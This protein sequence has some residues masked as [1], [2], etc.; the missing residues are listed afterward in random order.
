MMTMELLS[1]G[2][3]VL[4]FAGFAAAFDGHA[5]RLDRT[6]WSCLVLTGSV[7]FI[8]LV[9]DVAPW[10]TAMSLIGFLLSLVGVALAAY[11]EPEPESAEREP[12]WWPQFEREF[13]DY[14]R[15]ARP[16]EPRT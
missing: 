13:R 6:R 8:G 4:S 5:P 15:Q 14:V 10:A 7:L 3:F 9:V 2:G 11:A 1:L 16:H 12:V